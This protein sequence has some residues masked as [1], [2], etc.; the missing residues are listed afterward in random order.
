MSDTLHCPECGIPTIPDALYAVAP[1]EILCNKCYEKTIPVD[2]NKL[3]QHADVLIR[4]IAHEKAKQSMTPQILRVLKEVE[5]LVTS[6][7][8]D[9]HDRLRR[10]D[11]RASK[12]EMEHLFMLSQE[13]KSLI[14]DQ[15]VNPPVSTPKD[16]DVF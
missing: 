12:A 3:L 9:E 6:L 14:Q 1:D 10:S 2:A 15:E 7:Y 4:K 13:I 5:P 11:P 16:A 8:F